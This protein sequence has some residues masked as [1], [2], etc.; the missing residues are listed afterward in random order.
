M[1]S[2][3]AVHAAGSVAEQGKGYGIEAPL[4]SASVSAD[5]CLTSLV[6]GGEEFLRERGSNPRGVYLF[7]GGAFGLSKVTQ[8]APDR[9]VASGDRAEVT[10]TFSPTSISWRVQNLTKKKLITL[11]A[12]DSEI[13]AVRDV[14]GQYEKTPATFGSRTTTWFGQT[15]KLEITNGGRVWGPWSDQKLQIWQHDI[16]AESEHTTVLTPGAAAPDELAGVQAALNY[17]AVPPTDPTGPM[18]DLVKLSAPPAKRPAEGLS[19]DGVEAVFYDG[20]PYRGR[21]TQVFAW[22]GVP[23][24]PAGTT[25]PGMVLIHGGGGTAFAEWVRLWNTL[26]YAAIA[27]D[28]CGSVPGGK[29]GQRP[30]HAKGGPGGWGGYNQ[31]DHPREDQW[32]Y[33]AIADVILANSLLRS[34]PTVDPD[35]VGVTGISWGGYLCSMVA[36]VDS[37]FRFA[38]PVYGCG[39]TTDHNFAGSVNGLG[40]ERAARWM[41]W[42]DPSSYLA[43][44]QMPMLWVTGTNDFAYT[45]NA[46]QKS[47]R[48]PNTPRTLCIRLRMPHGHHAGWAP[49]EIAAFADSI[50]RDAPPLIRVTGQGCDD[51]TAWAAFESVSPVL[52]AELNVTSD[53]GPWK[54]R[55]WEAF[56]AQIET[57]R[58]SAELPADATVYYLNL[59]DERGL[60]VSTEHVE[61][62]E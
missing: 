20:L 41:R 28:T 2:D 31:I 44:A 53:A 14:H 45:F 48:L 13:R 36:G 52:K 6:V 29:P 38:V 59:T 19:E 4:Y 24:V 54:E 40:E 27:M 25:V 62:A 37:R 11:I 26:G 3:A 42:W 32:A 49:K 15:A 34:L 60:L 55:K 12:F 18:W 43:D 58:A 30:R 23:D 61:V 39:F 16:G 50:L 22:L 9:I 57:G 7:Q 47:Y 1:C 51:G 8:P 5:G 56:P 17:V 21:P 33:H 46:L 35:R 10:Y